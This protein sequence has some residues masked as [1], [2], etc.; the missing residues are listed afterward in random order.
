MKLISPRGF[1]SSILQPVLLHSNPRRPVSFSTVSTSHKPRIPLHL[2]PPTFR[3]TVADLKKWHTWAKNLASSVGST[4]SDLDNGPDSTLLHRELTWLIQDALENPTSVS[5]QNLNDD[6]MVPLRACLDDL[7]MLWSQRIE[8]RRPFQYVVGCEHWRDLV[9]S[10]EEGVLIPRP[11]TEMIVDLVNDA[12]KEKEELKEGLWA[13]LGTGSGALAIEIGRILGDSGKVIAT[14]L[15]P[16]AV[17]VASYNVQRYNLQD[18]IVVKQGSWFEPLKNFEGE[19]AGL[20]SNPPYIPSA[21]IGG[22]QAEVAKHEPRLALDGGANGMNDLLH[23]CNG[24]ISMLK[25]GGFVALETNGET[26]S[27]FLVD[28]M[29]TETKGSFHNVKIISDFAGIQRFVTG[30][31]AR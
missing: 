17:R 25:P 12:V 27:K 23:L 6:V 31:R 9:L 13:D 20:V 11:E 15:S 22:L 2:R 5:S 28:H 21:H 3:A 18:K 24:A 4:F 8:E 19:L 29:D 10:V 1:L 26:Q 7:Y 30:Y 16:V 14:D